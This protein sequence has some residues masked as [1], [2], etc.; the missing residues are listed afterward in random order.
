M[1]MGS[2]REGESGGGQRWQSGVSWLMNNQESVVVS[3]KILNGSATVKQ[4]DDGERGVVNCGATHN[5]SKPIRGGG[6]RSC[7]TCWWERP[8]GPDRWECVWRMCRVK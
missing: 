3:V 2:Y 1:R 8:Q 7:G 5:D 4:H 6:S